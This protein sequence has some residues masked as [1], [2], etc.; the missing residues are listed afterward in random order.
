MIAPV[1]QANTQPGAAYAFQLNFSSAYVTTQT[2]TLSLTFTNQQYSLLS[3]STP[4]IQNSNFSFFGTCRIICSSASCITQISCEAIN[5]Q[6]KLVLPSLSSLV[7]T[8][9]FYVL[10]PNFVDTTGIAAEIYDPNG[11]IKGI[12]IYNNLF[13]TTAIT[14]LPATVYLHWG[15]PWSVVNANMSLGLFVDGGWNT[16]D[17]GFTLDSVTTIGSQFTVRVYVGASFVL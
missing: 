5:N 4:L 8:V 9:E 15:I 10:N 12:S 14:I 3:A 11:L 7:Y 17:L 1:T 2:T 13:T 6:I 16:I